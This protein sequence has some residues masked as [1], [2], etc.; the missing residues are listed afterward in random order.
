MWYKPWGQVRSRASEYLGTKKKLRK[1][2]K[3]EFLTNE[4]P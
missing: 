3:K 4:T 2:E 1:A